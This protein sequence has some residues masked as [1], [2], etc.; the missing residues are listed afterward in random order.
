[1]NEPK[2]T[3]NHMVFN[4]RNLDEAVRF[5]TEVVGM[6]VVMRFDDRRMAFFHSAIIS[7]TSACSKPGPPPT[8]IGKRLAST[9]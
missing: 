2:K 4:V 9:T 5:Y 3:I 6:K 8:L 1:M 7:A